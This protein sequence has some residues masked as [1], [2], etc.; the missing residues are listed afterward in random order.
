MA[1]NDVLDVYHEVW[2]EIYQEIKATKKDA[3]IIAEEWADAWEM[4]DAKQWD[5]TMNYFKRRD[6]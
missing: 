3:A 4:Y 5:S 6:L 1:R 2:R